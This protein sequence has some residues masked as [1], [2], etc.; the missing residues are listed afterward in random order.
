MVSLEAVRANN[1]GLKNL[2]PGLVAV[3][4][5]GTSGIGE[6][7][8]RE[9]VRHTSSPRVYLVGRSQPDASRIIEE[10][11]AINPEGKVSFIKTDASLLRNVDEACKEIRS[12]EER[13]NL[14]FVSA[15]IATLKGRQEIDEGLDRKF[16]IHYYSRMRFIHNLLPLLTNAAESPPSSTTTTTPQLS[17]VISVLAA[18]QESSALHLT[19]LSLKTNFSDSACANHTI[20]MNSLAI[21]ELAAKFPRTTFIHAYPGIVKTKLDREFGWLMRGMWKGA[22]VLATPW[23]VPVKESGE[24]F[25][26]MATSK[27]FPPKT[28]NA[29]RDKGEAEEGV[30]RG[31][32]GV[33]GSGGYTLG[34]D[35]GFALKEKVMSKYRTEGVGKVVWEHTLDVF[36]KICGT[37]GGKY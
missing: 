32:D 25:V 20:T 28:E 2:G 14:L 37:G 24:R 3:F 13:V 1:T 12:K 23:V 5:G 27:R 10:L 7:T 22:S 4:V 34:W 16:S 17:R 6:T 31:S 8:A 11:K 21:E 30:E 15:G 33:R 35:G 36:N 18:G 9:F 29:M 26:F 19:D